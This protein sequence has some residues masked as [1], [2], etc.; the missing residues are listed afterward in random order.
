MILWLFE[1]VCAI[2][3]KS[4]A[5]A[6]WI[7]YINPFMRLADFVAGV[8]L[9]KIHTMKL[10]KRYHIFSYG[11]TVFI[12]IAAIFY[13]IPSILHCNITITYSA[14]W[15]PVSIFVI[16]MGALLK[17]SNFRNRAGRMLLLI[18]D[19]SMELFLIHQVVIRYFSKFAEGTF[20]FNWYLSVPVCFVGSL[21]IALV[22]KNHLAYKIRGWFKKDPGGQ[23][24]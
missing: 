12:P 7:L 23:D 9:G 18:G 16:E 5:N 14:L 19:L 8:L 1:I 15:F 6:H 10:G 17:D 2:V 24:G 20:C 21:I 4:Y 11:F 3:F 13:C 22:W